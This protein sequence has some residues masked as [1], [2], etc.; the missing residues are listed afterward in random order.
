MKFRNRRASSLV[1]T[2]LVLVVLS[3][4]V[5]AFMQSMAVER[6]TARSYKNQFQLELAIEAGKSAAVGTISSM[7]TNDAFI[8]VRNGNYSYIGSTVGADSNVIR[9]RPIFSASTNASQILATQNFATNAL[10]NIPVA[11]TYPSN[12]TRIRPFSDTSRYVTVS[13]IDVPATNNSVV[14]RYGFWVEDLGGKIDGAVAGN[15]LNATKHGR[16]TGTNLNEIALYTYFSTNTPVD[17]GDTNSRQ[18]VENRRFLLSP[19]TYL[20][21]SIQLSKDA[22]DEMAFNVPPVSTVARI[23]YGFGYAEAGQKK[24]NLNFYIANADVAGLAGAISTNLTGFANARKGALTDDY[25][26]TLAAN[27]IDYADADSTPTVGA[28]YRGVDSTPFVTILHDKITL[29]GVVSN[30]AYVEGWVFAQLWNPSDKQVSGTFNLEYN[31]HDDLLVGVNTG[32]FSSSVVSGYPFSSQNI[33]LPPNGITVLGF[34]P[35]S[36]AF[37]GGSFGTPTPPFSRNAPGHTRTSFRTTWNGQVVDRNLGGIERPN[38]SL[39]VGT[40]RWTGGLP[41]LRH[42]LSAEYNA[43]VANP[44]SG[45][46]RQLYYMSKNVAAH[47]YDA[48]TSWWG[49]AIMRPMPGRFM[50]DPTKWL[51]AAPNNSRPYPPT[52]STTSITVNATLS[53]IHNYKSQSGVVLTDPNEAPFI[54]NNTGTLSSATELGNV[55]DPALWSAAAGTT[56][57]I[58]TNANAT[59]NAGGGFLGGFSLRIGRPE[60]PKFASTGA[61]A[62]QLLDIFDVS[63]SV[64]DERVDVVTTNQKLNIN[65]AGTNALRALVAG[66]EL[67]RDL[68]QGTVTPPTNSEAV[69]K[70][71]ADAVIARRA[72][73]PFLSVAQLASV[74]NASGEIFGNRN[75]WI[76]GAPTN[77]FKDV[78]LEELFAKVYDLSAVNSRAFRVV[79]VGQVVNDKGKVLGSATKEFQIVFQP[80]R[81][82]DGNVISQIYRTFYEVSH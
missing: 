4:I 73:G 72:S 26:K 2:L 42:H 32:T 82:A 18:I 22:M 70:W 14:A 68:A 33:T 13:L 63:S 41:G 12:Q 17:I 75:Q 64:A 35:I 31:N 66:I 62:A 28:D 49:M 1:I 8:V 80:N 69:G 56:N 5:V 67:K 59:A 9:Y 3:T 60:H 43:A 47:D 29:T 79:V 15:L 77:T 34:G 51:D 44:P 78:G 24:R 37:P 45:D 23:P 11:G 39:P 71:F 27:I 7:L 53:T 74:T 57:G 6:A 10:P 52:N 46:P 55:F 16:P 76:S 36:Y 40:A 61:R 48:R 81:D 58:P 30:T 19:K 65:T 54:F 38:G 25:N 20:Q 50:T 21:E